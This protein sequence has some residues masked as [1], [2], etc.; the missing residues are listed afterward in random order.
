MTATNPI[1]EKNTARLIALIGWFAVIAQFALMLHSGKAPT[2]EL[3]IRFFSYFTILTNGIV[4]VCASVIGWRGNGFATQWRWA[5]AVYIT[6]V[7][8]VYNTVLRFLWAPDGLRQ[9]VDELL[10]TV[11]PVA[12][13]WHCLAFAR[14]RLGWNAFW[15]WLLY[16][17]LYLGWV[18]V[19]G[20]AS[21]FYPYPFVDVVQVGYEKVAVNCVL[22]TAVFVVV[23]LIY[24][25][26]SR[27]RFS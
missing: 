15:I 4:A 22:V 25:W 1:P 12:F 8:L 27:K 18:L 23:S 11:I 13:V 26:I 7:G 3:I 6:V 10:H 24:I 21:G 19:R 2:G 5:I 9:L 16:P 20:A 17:L 14:V